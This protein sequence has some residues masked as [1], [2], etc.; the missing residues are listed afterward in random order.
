M[1]SAICNNGPF[2]GKAMHCPEDRV[3]LFKQFGRLISYHRALGGPL[4][5]DIE[6]GAYVFNDGRWEWTK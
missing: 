2:H 3:E 6:V 1:F 5:A 4:P